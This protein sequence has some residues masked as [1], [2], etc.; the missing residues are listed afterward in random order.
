MLINASTKHMGIDKL[1]YLIDKYPNCKYVV[2]HLENDTR[3]KLK[4][5]NYKN[6]I[7]PDDGYTIEL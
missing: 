2:S 5:L 7:V 1:E 3:E 6:V 4:E